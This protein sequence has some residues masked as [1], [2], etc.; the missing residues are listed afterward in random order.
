VRRLDAAATVPPLVHV[1]EFAADRAVSLLFPRLD[2]EVIRV[3]RAAGT[4]IATIARR[5]DAGVTC[6]VR[7][8]D[9]RLSAGRYD[10]APQGELRALAVLGRDHRFVRDDCRRV[11]ARTR[12][13]FDEPEARFAEEALKTLNDRPS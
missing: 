6:L 10:Y 11:L 1:G 3:R 5:T 4:A 12:E 9:R 2:D 8:L 7:L 13:R